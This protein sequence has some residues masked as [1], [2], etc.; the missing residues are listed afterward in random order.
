MS[1]GICA[2][3][4]LVAP[5][6]LAAGD[7]DADW[8]WAVEQVPE[9]VRFQRAPEPPFG[10]WDER[11]VLWAN[12]GDVDDDCARLVFRRAGD[13]LATEVRDTLGGGFVPMGPDEGGTYQT[14]VLGA[15]AALLGPS[16]RVV[17]ADGTGSGSAYGGFR[18][19]GVL[20]SVTARGVVYTEEEPG[21]R[22]VVAWTG[23]Q[24][25]RDRDGEH[26]VGP[27]PVLALDSLPPN[28]APGDVTALRPDVLCPSFYR[29]PPALDAD[30]LAADAARVNAIVARERLVSPSASGP[31]F[32]RSRGACRQWV[33]E[34]DGG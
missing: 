33:R 31:S 18:T 21:P 14:L 7:R 8:A 1:R 16:H 13:E 26:H 29:S 27:L 9:L 22:V 4:F 15:S 6:L 20:S 5:G 12:A 34:R 3:L 10:D 2:L 11:V 24:T 17:G 32:W 23:A 25:C 28:Q 30:A 19:L